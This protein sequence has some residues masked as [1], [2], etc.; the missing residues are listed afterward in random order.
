MREVANA[1]EYAVNMEQTPYIS[2]ESL[3]VRGAE[4]DG[5]PGGGGGG[6]RRDAGGDEAGG[7]GVG[8]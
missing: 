2:F 8:D 6:V 1:V 7:G 5:E 3:P 4:G